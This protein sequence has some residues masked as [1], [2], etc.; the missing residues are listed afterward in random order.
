L[1][2]I[3]TEDFLLFLAAKAN[4][5]FKCHFCGGGQFAV[6][7]DAEDPTPDDVPLALFKLPCLPS[8]VGGHEFHSITCTNCG[9]T[10]FFHINQIGKWQESRV[11]EPKTQESQEEVGADV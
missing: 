11:K 2:V 9:N 7:V 4:G 10:Y 6:N 8:G 3:T 1:A 5:P